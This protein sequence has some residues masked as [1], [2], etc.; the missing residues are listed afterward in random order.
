MTVPKLFASNAPPYEPGL[1][2]RWDVVAFDEVAG[3]H[4]KRPEDKQLY[5]DYMELGLDGAKMREEEIRFFFFT[6]DKHSYLMKEREAQGI[7]TGD[8][9]FV[10]GFPLGIRGTSQ[11]Y[12]I[13]R[14]GIIAR[15]DEEVLKDHYFFVDVSAYPGN[16]GGPV[17]IEVDIIS[18]GNT[19]HVEQTRLIGV[20]SEG[21][22][23]REIAVSQQ[24]RAP[25]VVFEEQTGL[26]KAVPI[27]SV[28][29]AI[30]LYLQKK[31]VP[32]AEKSV[33]SEVPKT[34]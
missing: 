13:A 34:Y 18:V 17:V 15:V 19:K 27:D 31:E 5:K 26:V 30:D 8:G 2:T 32:V 24:T 33:D 6:D 9:V 25:R 22:A 21:V 11:N 12:V 4:F 20:V 7:S 29:E 16:S 10:L 14:K 28:I 1:V 23:Y 3:S